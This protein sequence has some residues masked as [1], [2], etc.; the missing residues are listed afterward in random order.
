[1]DDD[2]FDFP[3]T[4]Q[5]EPRHG[6]EISSKPMVVVL[7]TVY[8]TILQKEYPAD[9]LLPSELDMNMMVQ[10]MKHELGFTEDQFRVTREELIEALV[11]EHGFRVNVPYVHEPD[12]HNPER[13]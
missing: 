3:A 10:D 2:D 11:K 4:E 12:F 5:D 9:E 1:M 13:Y 6:L 8:G 7:L